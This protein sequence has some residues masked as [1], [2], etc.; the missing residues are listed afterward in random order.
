VIR[1]ELARIE[2]TP[3]S[4]EAP[5][6][7]EGRA[8]SSPDIAVQEYGQSELAAGPLGDRPCRPGCPPTVLRHDR[9]DGNHVRGT[10]AG[11]D[12]DVLAKV[13]QLDRRGDPGHERLDKRFVLTHE[14]KDRAV[15]VLVGVHVEEAGVAGKRCRQ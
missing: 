6:T 4:V 9:N 8:P 13:D 14:G 15:M 2:T 12:A 7:E 3:E 5:G 1:H 11:V 10:D